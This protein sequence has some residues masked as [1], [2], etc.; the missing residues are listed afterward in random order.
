MD[1]STNDEVVTD[2]LVTVEAGAK[3]LSVSVAF[4]YA[5][6]T[7]GELEFVKLGRARRIPRRALI[8]F[9]ARGLRGGERSAAGVPGD[10]SASGGDPPR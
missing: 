5:M 10:S 1:R 3:F 4:L 8:E 7:R 6:M 2:G 9:A